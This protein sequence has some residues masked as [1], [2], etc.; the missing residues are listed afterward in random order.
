MNPITHYVTIYLMIAFVWGL[1]LG[2]I[3]AIMYRKD[4]RS[5]MGAKF[6][7]WALFWPLGII[8]SIFPGIRKGFAK[9]AN[10]GKKP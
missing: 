6:G 10:Q 7:L 1:I 9:L 8:L 4:E 2:V 3:L 5:L